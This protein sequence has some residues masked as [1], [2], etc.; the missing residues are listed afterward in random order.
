MSRIQILVKSLIEEASQLNSL[1]GGGEIQSG[2]NSAPAAIAAPEKVVVD[3]TNTDDHVNLRR[4]SSSSSSAGQPLSTGAATALPNHVLL[5]SGSSSSATVGSLPQPAKPIMP[6]QGPPFLAKPPPSLPSSN[7][8]ALSGVS[9]VRSPEYPG[10]QVSSQGCSRAYIVN[11]EP[12]P[13][14]TCC[15]VRCVDFLW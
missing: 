1:F 10:T 15:C 11:G 5:Q 2:T 14:Q 4:H 8:L 12:S 6:K 7:S 13:L 3:L 9:S